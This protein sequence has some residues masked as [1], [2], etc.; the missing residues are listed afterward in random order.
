VD[1]AK[2]I[3]RNGTIIHHL[4]A[5]KNFC[6]EAVV[7]MAIVSV[8]WRNVKGSVFIVKSCYLLAMIQLSPTKVLSSILGIMGRN[9]VPFWGSRIWYLPSF[10]D[11][12]EHHSQ[13]D[14]CHIFSAV[15]NVKDW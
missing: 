13:K 1:P 2:V 6:M 5:A 9:N 15:S 8:P 7:A 14:P 12:S 4:V 10:V 3:S 11:R